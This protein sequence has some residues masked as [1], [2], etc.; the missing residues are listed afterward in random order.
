M[1]FTHRLSHFK[2]ALD[3]QPLF[4]LVKAYVTLIVTLPDLNFR[5]IKLE[6]LEP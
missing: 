4:L 2:M 1:L 3:A 6:V 5:K